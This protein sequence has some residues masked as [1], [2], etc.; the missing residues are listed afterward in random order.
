MRTGLLALVCLPGLVGGCG[1][2]EEAFS[3][4]FDES[5]IKSC[6]SSAVKTGAP[7]PG[8]TQICDCALAGIN[9]KYSTTEKMTLSGEDAAPIMDACVKQAVEA[10][11]SG[12]APL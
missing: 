9:V 1:N 4:Q 10:T 5:F 7:S 8:A 2:T 12:Q 6:V 11:I 3:K